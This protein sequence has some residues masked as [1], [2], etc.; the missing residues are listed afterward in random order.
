[1][2]APLWPIVGRDY[3]RVRNPE[4]RSVLLYGL[5]TAVAA[6]LTLILTRVLWRALTPEAF[7]LWALIDPILIP[8][9]SLMLLGVNHAI[10]KQLQIDR[11]PL[12]QV[13]GTLLLAGLPAALACLLLLGLVFF[14]IW[15]LPR[16]D[17]N[18][19]GVGGEALINLFE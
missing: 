18:Q 4:V 3:L 14:I 17:A 10:V 7:G 19:F 9:G 5:S 15:H 11:T 2:A 13:V 8:A 1:M 12:N 16:T 6:G